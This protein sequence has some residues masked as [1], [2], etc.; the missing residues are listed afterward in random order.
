LVKVFE[1]T[2]PLLG[3]GGQVSSREHPFQSF[4]WS[5]T[6]A[7]P[8]HEYTYRVLPLYGSPAT[9]TEKGGVSVA[10]STEPELGAPHSVFFN[11]GAVASQEVSRRFEGKAPDELD[12]RQ[13]DAAY[14]PRA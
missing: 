14:S 9:L 2:D 7:K 12:A 13:K 4:Q 3:P 8:S 1:A 5:E 10:V 11:R 6:S